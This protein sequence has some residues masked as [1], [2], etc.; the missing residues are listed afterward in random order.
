MVGYAGIAKRVAE[1][2]PGASFTLIV[3]PTRR[4]IATSPHIRVK[5]FGS[6][7]PVH[8][9]DMGRTMIVAC[10]VTA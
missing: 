8:G 4:P 6:M 5:D 7:S 2:W 1:D 9:S 3:T 10:P